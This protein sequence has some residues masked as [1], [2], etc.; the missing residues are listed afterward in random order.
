M[1]EQFFFFLGA[2]AVGWDGLCQ[3]PMKSNYI[4]ILCLLVYLTRR[5]NVYF[6]TK[7]NVPL[8]VSN[9][10][11]VDNYNV[12]KFV[13]RAAAFKMQHL[14]G[15]GNGQVCDKEGCSLLIRPS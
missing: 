5:V 7:S 6:S 12:D 2:E 1:H 15:K 9:I 10:Q 8:C 13:L 14:E 11:I 4:L 3:T